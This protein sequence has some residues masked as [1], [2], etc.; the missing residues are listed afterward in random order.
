VGTALRMGWLLVGR[1]GAPQL[2]GENGSQ[3]GRREE[4]GTGRRE[5]GSTSRRGS[6]GKRGVG[7]TSR[8]GTALRPGYSLDGKARCT[9]AALGEHFFDAPNLQARC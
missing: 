8:R 7:S 1:L 5:G 2:G 3:D 4:I 6:T 9:T